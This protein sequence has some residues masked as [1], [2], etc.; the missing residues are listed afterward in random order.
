MHIIIAKVDETYFDGEADS[1]TV[2]GTAGEMTVLPKHMPLI[3]TLK[4]GS[5]LLRNGDEEK[6]F[7]VDGGVVE[8]RRDGA[9][10]V[11]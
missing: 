6:E 9:T 8:V 11:L 7:P 1:M 4:P 3:T 10:V 2:P 5:I